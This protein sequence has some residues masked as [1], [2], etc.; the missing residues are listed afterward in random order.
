MG[1]PILCPRME[2]LANFLL[3]SFELCQLQTGME[4]C[5]YFSFK[6]N[7]FTGLD[8]HTE[9]RSGVSEPLQM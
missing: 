1:T 4:Q 8:K 7:Q 3:S 5:D 2:I 6:N 9:L